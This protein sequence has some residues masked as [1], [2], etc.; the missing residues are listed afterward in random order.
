MEKKKRESRNG[1]LTHTVC[2]VYCVEIRTAD[3]EIPR[4][5]KKKSIESYPR[6]KQHTHRTH[7][8]KNDIHVSREECYDGRSDSD[9]HD[10]D[11]EK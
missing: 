5:K 4:T 3:L 10:D 1:F 2:I 6:T 7:T 9:R 11:E 8:H